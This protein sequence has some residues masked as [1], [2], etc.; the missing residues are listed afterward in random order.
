M[1][2]K[3]T[4]TPFFMNINHHDY[5]FIMKCLNW[6]ISYND[7]LDTVLFDPP[8][9]APSPPTD[10]QQKQQKD[11]FYM[12]LSMECIS[13]FVTQEDIPIAFLEQTDLGV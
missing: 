2:V 10:P 1:R 13:L 9:N 5:S 4:M 12:T 3:C 11:P 8:P 7:G 6:A